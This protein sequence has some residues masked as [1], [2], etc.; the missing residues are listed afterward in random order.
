MYDKRKFYDENFKIWQ[1]SVSSSQFNQMPSK[2]KSCPI[3]SNYFDGNEPTE[4]KFAA[5]G[6]KKMSEWMNICD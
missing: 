3:S 2:N 6:R 4:I 1:I 5:C